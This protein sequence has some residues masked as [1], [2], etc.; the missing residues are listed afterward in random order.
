MKINTRHFKFT[1]I[2]CFNLTISDHAPSEGSVVLKDLLAG[3]IHFLVWLDPDG[4][5][6]SRP[7]INFNHHHHHLFAKNTYNTTCKKNK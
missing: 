5:L 7:L 4:K 6:I 2:S 1:I 3:V